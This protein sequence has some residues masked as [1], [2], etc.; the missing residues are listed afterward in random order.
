M[1][2]ICSF[3]VSYVGYNLIIILL[4]L[5]ND[6]YNLCLHPCHIQEQEMIEAHV[7]LPWEQS[8]LPWTPEITWITTCVVISLFRFGSIYPLHLPFPFFFL[9]H[10]VFYDTIATFVKDFFKVCVCYISIL[11]VLH[12]L[13]DLIV[14]IKQLRRAWSFHPEPLSPWIV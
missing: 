7:L 8:F 6:N 2:F 3:S 12:C 13:C 1:I 11:I 9:V 4:L 10:L 14:V 5:A